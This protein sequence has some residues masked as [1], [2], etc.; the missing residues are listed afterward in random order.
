MVKMIFI[1]PCP[2]IIRAINKFFESFAVF[3]IVL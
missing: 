2:N 3:V 1:K